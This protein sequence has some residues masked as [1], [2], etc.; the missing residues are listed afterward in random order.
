MVKEG[1][2]QRFPCDAVYGIHNDPQQAFGTASAVA[3]TVLAA[4]DRLSITVRGRGGHG[5]QPHLA[6]DP[7]LAATHVVQ[8]L[9]SIASRRIDPLDGVVVSITQFHAGSAYNVIPDAAELGGTVRTL[10]AATQD[11]VEGLIALI[12]GRTAEAHDCTAEVVYQRGYPPTVNHAEQTDRA[13]AALGE[14]LDPARIARSAPPIM[15]A[16]DFSFF[17]RERPGAFLILGQR[18]P[19]GT[20]GVAVHNPHYDFNDALLPVGAAY[21]ARLVE[22]ELPR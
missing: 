19:D 6:V 10:L 16:E 4:S 8:A 3:G 17:L 9:Q 14:V 7:V 20:G 21:F 13:A 12:A 5:A 2:F 18:Q 22:R 1:L 15:G 11:R